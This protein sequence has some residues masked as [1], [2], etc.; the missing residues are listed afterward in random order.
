VS[1]GSTAKSSSNELNAAVASP[2]APTAVAVDDD[3]IDADAS[4]A[5]ALALALARTLATY[6]STRKDAAAMHAMAISAA[7]AA[8]ALVAAPPTPLTPPR[9]GA[10]RRCRSRAGALPNVCARDAAR[11]TLAVSIVSERQ[12]MRV[13]VHRTAKR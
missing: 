11:E 12:R 5:L 3:A 13:L 9:P 10:T 1:S 2:S 6:V 4:T 7:T 8:T